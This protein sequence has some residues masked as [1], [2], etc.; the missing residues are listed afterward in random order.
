MQASDW[1]LDEIFPQEDPRGP[2][3]VHHQPQV[4]HRADAGRLRS[5]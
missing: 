5:P 2:H 4:Q 1:L 3:H